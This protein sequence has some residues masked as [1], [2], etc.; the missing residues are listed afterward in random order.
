MSTNLFHAA[1]AEKQRMI[2]DFIR[3]YEKE[4]PGVKLTFLGT[5]TIEQMADAL[6]I[7]GSQ[8]DLATSQRGSIQ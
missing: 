1:E 7:A 8:Q 3:R 2:V 4:H 5:T 6:E